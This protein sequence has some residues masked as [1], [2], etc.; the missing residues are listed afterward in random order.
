MEALG[1]LLGVSMGLIVL[2][3]ILGIASYIIGSL[4][5]MSVGKDAGLSNGWMAWIPICNILY[6]GDLGELG[7][8]K[9]NFKTKM[10]VSGIGAIVFSVLGSIFADS[11]IAFVFTVIYCILMI[12]Y[13][14]FSIQLTY[15]IYERYIP[16]YAVVALVLS[17]LFAPAALI[18][19]IIVLTKTGKQL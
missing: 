12:A 11:S 6:A 4:Y 8:G 16:S 19:E 14:V 7:F 2:L 18:F 5:L 3:F 17:I 1:F 10:L 13:A 9:E 15:W